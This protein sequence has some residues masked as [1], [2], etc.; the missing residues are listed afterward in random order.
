MMRHVKYLVIVL[1][2]LLVVISS[3]TVRAQG[4]KAIRYGQ[5]IKSEITDAAATLS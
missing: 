5:T 3:S 1:G 4:G 2:L